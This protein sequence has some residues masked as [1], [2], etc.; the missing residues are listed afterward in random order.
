M[1]FIYI[2]LSPTIIWHLFIYKRGEGNGN[3]L[4][5][6]CLENPMDG[7]APGAA[8][9][10]VTKSQTRLNDFTF[11]FHFHALE[12]EMAAHSSVLAWRIPG[13]GEPGGLT[14]VGSHRI[15][16]DWSD[17]AAAA[18]YT[19]V[20]LWGLWDPYTKGLR[21]SKNHPLVHWVIVIHTSNSPNYRHYS[22]L[23]TGSSTSWPWSGSPGDSGLFY[24]IPHR[25]E[26]LS[27]CSEVQQKSSSTPLGQKQTYKQASK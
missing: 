21:K 24:I 3:P 9:H 23:W 27:G 26:G 5:Y 12:K 18:A 22:G 7:G 6:S 10:E 20:P 14:S 1:S 2:L 19:K 15:G 8:V 13:T 17:L 11:T 4:R 16:H 25:W